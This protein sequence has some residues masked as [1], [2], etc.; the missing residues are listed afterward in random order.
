MQLKCDEFVNAVPQHMTIAPL[1]VLCDTS[2]SRTGCCV[3]LLKTYDEI[4]Q[5]ILTSGAEFAPTI[6]IGAT[7]GSLLGPIPCLIPPVL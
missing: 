5:Y 6:S 2:N 1:I 3:N 7:Q 4:I